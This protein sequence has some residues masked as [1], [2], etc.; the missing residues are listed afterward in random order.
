MGLA[1]APAWLA[2]ASLATPLA[3]LAVSRARQGKLP[4]EPPPPPD[5]ELAALRNRLAAIEGS[6]SWR[7]TAPLR[8]LLDRLRRP[9]QG[10]ERPSR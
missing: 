3:M 5:P 6:T 10:V 2:G 9:P 8:R 7:L 1:Y 4:P